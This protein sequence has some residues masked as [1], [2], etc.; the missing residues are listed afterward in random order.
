MSQTATTDVED[1]GTILRQAIVSYL[2]QTGA[3]ERFPPH[4]PPA[5]VDGKVREVIRSWNL[6]IPEHICEKAIV[7]GVDV[8]FAAYRH[9]PYDLQIVI[10]L[11]TFCATLF[12]DKSLDSKAMRE[13]VPRFCLGQPQLHPLLDRFIE[14]TMNLPKFFPLYTANLICSAVL[15]YA[16][17]DVYWREHAEKTT[18]HPSAW[19]YV[20]YSRLKSGMPETFVVSI[21]PSSICPTLDEYVQAIPDALLFVDQAKKPS[22]ISQVTLTSMLLFTDGPSQNPWQTL[23]RS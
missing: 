3:A 11:L 9:T 8:G 10:A 6:D 13:F 18:L 23:W 21:W 5:V 7:V 2:E 15:L 20:E 12:D 14:C 16:N 4:P 22:K 17:E 1:I 19:Q